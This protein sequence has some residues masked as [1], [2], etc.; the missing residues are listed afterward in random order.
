M[1]LNLSGFFVQV[2]DFTCPGLSSFFGQKMENIQV[3]GKTHLVT[4]LITHLCSSYNKPIRIGVVTR[5]YARKAA[6]MPLCPY[7][8]M[9]LCPYAPMPLC[10]YATNTLPRVFGRFE[11]LTFAFT[12]PM[13]INS[14]IKHLG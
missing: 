2:L 8:P 9:P 4:L 11:G 14:N 13:P 1:V 6:P 10:P 12:T 5:T 3:F 7:A